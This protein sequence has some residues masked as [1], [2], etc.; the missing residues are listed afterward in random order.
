MASHRRRLEVLAVNAAMV[1]RRLFALT[2][3]VYLATA[4]GSLTTTDAV[5]TFDV[6]QSMVKH[7]SVAMSG[8]LLGREA[9]RGRDGRYYS[10]FGIG[11]SLVNLPFYLAAKVF[12][13]ATGIRIGKSDSLLKAAVAL[14]QTVVVAAIVQ[15]FFFFAVEAVGD[16]GAA[17]LAA[18]TLGVGSLLWPYAR[19]GFNQPLACLTLLAASR[20]ALVGMRRSSPRHLIYAGVWLAASLMTRHEMALA[21]L[22]IAGWLWCDGARPLPE[23]LRRVAF[24]SPGLLAGAAAWL[25]YNVIRFG[26][27]LDSGYLRDPA[28]GFGSPVAA[29]M[30]ALL[31]SPSAS[32][33]LYSPVALAG[34]AG[35]VVLF[36][37]RE[38]STALFSAAMILCFL[39]F[40]AS[41][42]NWIGGR[43]YGGRYL[44]IVLPYFGVGWAAAL[45]ALTTRRRVLAVALVGGL[46]LAVQ[47]PG[48]LI[49]Y[50]K[51][52]QA[53]GSA[54]Q[55]FSTEE[56]Q[57]RWDA[58][59]LVLNSRAL[60]RAWPDNIDYL[61]GRRQP[62]PLAAPVGEGDRSFSQQFSFSLDLWWLY[63][64]YLHV[65][66]RSAV[67][68]VIA[69]FAA[70]IAWMG[71]RVCR[72]VVRVY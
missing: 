6:T 27:P 68:L 60:V 17:G 31:A 69:A 2:L 39:V 46:G 8:N 45:A 47:L 16:I 37:S 71:L 52:S 12:V 35:L 65:L 66:S 23:R 30:A 4:G 29:G 59:P 53:V 43:S 44:L 33:F 10:P 3:L 62:P 1:G 49:D 63:L 32:V 42:G 5:V 7:G 20:C 54:Q 24:F 51:V 72:D 34:L 11:Q 13:G 21:A 50:A 26:N 18:L 55:P 36:R 48:V 15:Q 70:A 64:F 22:P 58:A 67:A 40:Y 41:L 9:E 14:G 38:R 57:W 61:L 25:V 56:R 19:F 28:P